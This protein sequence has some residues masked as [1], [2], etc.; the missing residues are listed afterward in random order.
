MR[1]L[2]LL[3]T[4]TETHTL[5]AAQP[6]LIFP[7]LRELCRSRFVSHKLASTALRLLPSSILRRLN[8]YILH[9]WAPE[10]AMAVPLL[11]SIN[12]VLLT[13]LEPRPQWLS[14]PPQ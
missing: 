5:P 1:H 2:P 10:E 13:F 3:S 6:R 11:R 12:H 7:S 9:T 8:R 14:Q 4:L